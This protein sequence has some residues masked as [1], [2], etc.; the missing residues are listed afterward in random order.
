MVYPNG[1]NSVVCPFD[2]SL[3]RMERALAR[4]LDNVQE[5]ASLPEDLP[6]VEKILKLV[7]LK[8]QLIT[9]LAQECRSLPNN[10]GSDET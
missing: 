6:H 9:I 10:I 3:V 1:N 8:N 5:S 2:R 4:L 7:F